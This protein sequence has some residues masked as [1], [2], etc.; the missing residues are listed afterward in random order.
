MAT[1]DFLGLPDGMAGRVRFLS[2][3]AS[4]RAQDAAVYRRDLVYTVDYATTLSANLPRLLFED[5]RVFGDGV[6]IKTLLS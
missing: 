4:D 3:T 6:L 2:S 1:Y 5:T